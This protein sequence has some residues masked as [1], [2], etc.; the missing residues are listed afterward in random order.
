MRLVADVDRAPGIA[1]LECTGAGPD[2]IVTLA[3]TDL[4]ITS[5]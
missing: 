1:R 2:R 3:G 5:A 4:V